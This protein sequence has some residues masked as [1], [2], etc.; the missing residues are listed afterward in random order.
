M[1]G[2]KA[3]KPSDI[4]ALIVELEARTTT[5]RNATGQQYPD[6]VTKSIL[7]NMVDDETRKHVAAYTGVEYNYVQFKSKVLEMVHVQA[8]HDKRGVKAM[9]IGNLEEGDREDEEETWTSEQWAG[10]YAEG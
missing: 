5:Y 1:N 7:L 6:E 9:D 2:K 8:D 10:W 4:R 3:K